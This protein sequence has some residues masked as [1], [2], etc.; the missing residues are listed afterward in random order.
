[1][2]DEGLLFVLGGQ[3]YAHERTS[4]FT[5]QSL[6]YSRIKNDLIV[7]VDC[8]GIDGDLKNELFKSD[9]TTMYNIKTINELVDEVID[10]LGNNCP[11][12]RELVNKRK[13]QQI[14][15]N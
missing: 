4:F 6:G 12:L 15:E 14:N 3:H 7:I 13:E 9:K 1:M 11:Q 10:F 8:T 5:K 2:S